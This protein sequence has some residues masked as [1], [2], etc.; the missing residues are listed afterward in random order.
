M[1]KKLKKLF[2]D[3]TKMTPI[4]SKVSV[5]LATK[6]EDEEF[7]L[8]LHKNGYRWSKSTTLISTSMWGKDYE[9]EKVHFVYP[10]KRVTYRGN[11]TSDTLTFTEFKKRY[12]KN[13]DHIVQNHKMVDNIVKDGF[14]EHNRLHIASLAMQG[15]LSN[16]DMFNKVLSAGAETL[17]G[18][19]IS[20]RAVA[21]A[22]LLFADALIKENKEESPE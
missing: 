14:R 5:Y 9:D 11:R 15:I 22:S 12:F 10:D 3:P 13:E 6:E 2:R 8:L 17:E 18:E 21:K 7:R 16:N 19:N 4:K 1:F 20:Y